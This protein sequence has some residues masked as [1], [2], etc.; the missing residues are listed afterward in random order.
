MKAHPTR[1]F[2]LQIIK[3]IVWIV[4]A[5]ALVKFAFFPA[6]EEMPTI[7]GQGDFTLPTVAVERGDI[8]NTQKFDGTIVRDESSAFKASAEGTINYLF[9]G[10]GASVN[11]GERVLQ[12]RSEAAVTSD[13]PEAEPTTA[14]R[15]TDV[16]APASGIIHLDAMIGQATT[17]GDLLGSI[18]PSTFHAAVPLTADQLY[19]LQ[20]APT[21][22]EILITDG[23]APFTCTNLRTT[24]V[25]SAATGDDASGA[26]PQASSTPELR[27]D[28]PTDQQVFDGLKAKLTITGESAT[29]VLVV[30]TTAVE[31]RFREGNVYLPSEDPKAKPQAV[32]VGI[33]INDGEYVEITSGIDEGAEIL[34]FVPSLE[35]D[36]NQDGDGVMMGGFGG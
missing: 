16:I 18:E 35:D 34:Q 24:T 19:T 14:V 26:A 5:A 36:E 2:V 8:E 17:I 23:P 10:D 27:C 9:V 1:T 25:A 28:I 31:G 13:D 21:E 12:I 30:P 15:Y 29:D 20:G 6:Q 4:I 32:K 22:A 11:K 33:G 7:A 3:I